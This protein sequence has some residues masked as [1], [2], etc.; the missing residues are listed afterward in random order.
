MYVVVSAAEEARRKKCGVLVHCLAGI[1]RSVTITVAYLMHSQSLSLNDAYDHVKRCK[2]NISPNFNFM[3]QLLDY[4][5]ALRLQRDTDVA[6]PSS[7]CCCQTPVSADSGAEDLSTS[8]A[9]VD[10][11]APFSSPA[12]SSLSSLSTG[13][14]SSSSS[15]SAFNYEIPPSSQTWLQSAASHLVSVLWTASAVASYRTAVAFYTC[16]GILLVPGC[17]NLYEGLS[18][19]IYPPKVPFAARVEC[20]MACSGNL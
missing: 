20:I 6:A 16:P 7:E 17:F 10:R 1:S 18:A 9:C 2:P 5:R 12:S 8:C 3:G 4:E 11:L 13:A 19:I 15:S 14:T